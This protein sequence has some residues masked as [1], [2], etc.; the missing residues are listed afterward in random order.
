MIENYQCGGQESVSDSISVIEAPTS[1]D[2]V[3]TIETTFYHI[4]HYAATGHVV[5]FSL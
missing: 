3:R 1:T 4:N 2:Y 5:K